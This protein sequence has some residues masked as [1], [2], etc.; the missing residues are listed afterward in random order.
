MTHSPQEI[1][2][3]TTSIL[4]ELFDLDEEALVPEAKLY[5]DLDIDSIDAVDLLIELKKIVGSGIK[6]DVFKEAKT[7]QDVVDT[8]VVLDRQ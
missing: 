4:Q 6:P 1:W 2:T 7:L 8:I 5:D 3:K